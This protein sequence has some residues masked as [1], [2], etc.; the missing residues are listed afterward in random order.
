MIRTLTSLTLCL[1][2]FTAHAATAGLK[3]N[4]RAKKSEKTEKAAKRPEILTGIVKIEVLQR[5][6]GARV[7]KTVEDP[8]QIENALSQL[9]VVFPQI[10]SDQ[11][12]VPGG[13]GGY[14]AA[15]VLTLHRSQ[16]EPTRVVV[17]SNWKL[18]CW[19][20]GKAIPAGEW[21]LKSPAKA[22]QLLADLLKSPTEDPAEAKK[23]SEVKQAPEVK[24]PAK[25]R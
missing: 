5:T 15:M 2:F 18:W 20:T 16:G 22:K 4:P 14:M 12:P 3:P 25:T 10:G 19:S 23:G 11:Q 1:A 9:A 24:K 8:Q 6:D 17:S 21:Y 7:T 13:H